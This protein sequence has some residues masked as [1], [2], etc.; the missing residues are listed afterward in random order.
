MDISIGSRSRVGGKKHE[1]YVAAFGSNLFYGLFLQGYGAMAP[2]PL[3]PLLNIFR[4]NHFVAN[5][6]ENGVSSFL[7]YIFFSIL[8]VTIWRRDKMADYDEP[9]SDQE[10]VGFN[11]KYDPYA[12][13]RTL[14]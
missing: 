4:Q 8:V 5:K 7:T 10:K 12:M 6:T 1:I 13:T 2:R 14:Q 3:D 9:I 11:E